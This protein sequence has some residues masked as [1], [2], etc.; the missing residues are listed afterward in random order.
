LFAKIIKEISK[1]Q[2][3]FVVNFY[4]IHNLKKILMALTPFL[5]HIK[6]KEFLVNLNRIQLFF[7]LFDLF[8]NFVSDSVLKVAFNRDFLNPLIQI[9]FI[10][11]VFSSSLIVC[12]LVL[13]ETI[14]QSYRNCV[15][16]IWMNILYTFINALQTYGFLYGFIPTY[17]NSL[18]N[19]HVVII[20][21]FV[22]RCVLAFVFFLLNLYQIVADRRARINKREQQLTE[23]KKPDRKS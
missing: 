20:L 9:A 4:S 18:D 1:Q 23:E 6:M 8:I 14:S 2:G 17:F 13:Y 21:H 16:M 7:F 22:A 12:F 10:S 11:V 15:D 5:K 19:E 3:L